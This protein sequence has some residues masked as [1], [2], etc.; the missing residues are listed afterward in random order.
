MMGGEDGGKQEQ[1][2]AP[3]HDR[4]VQVHDTCSTWQVCE[5]CEGREGCEGCDGCAERTVGYRIDALVAFWPHSIL[6]FLS[7]RFGVR[8]FSSILRLSFP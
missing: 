6:R 1:N 3:P 7:F 8:G 2:P 4:A 5:V